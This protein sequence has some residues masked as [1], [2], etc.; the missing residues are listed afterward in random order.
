MLRTFEYGPYETKI[1]KI[2]NVI[3]RKKQ[4]MERWWIRLVAS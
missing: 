3:S 2:I 4:T 1:T